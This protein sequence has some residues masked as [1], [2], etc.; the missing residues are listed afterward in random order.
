MQFLMEAGILT[1]LGGIIGVLVGIALAFVVSKAS[2]V[3]IFISVPVM[4]L[5]VVFS[6]VV[7]LFFGAFPAT[8]AAKLNPIDALRRE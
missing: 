7:G 8:Q 2:S 5:A 6:F 1:C 3:P 4:G